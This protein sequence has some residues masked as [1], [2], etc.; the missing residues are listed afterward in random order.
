MLLFI[1]FWSYICGTHWSD[2]EKLEQKQKKIFFVLI[3]ENNQQIN[4]KITW[5]FVKEKVNDYYLGIRGQKRRPETRGNEVQEKQQ[6]NR[7]N[8]KNQFRL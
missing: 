4:L 5:N 1:N 3:G 7:E 2:G 6:K 8:G